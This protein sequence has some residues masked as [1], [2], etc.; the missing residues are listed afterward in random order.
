MLKGAFFYLTHHPTLVGE[1]ALDFSYFPSPHRLRLAA[2]QF[3]I[4]SHAPAFVLD[5]EIMAQRLKVAKRSLKK[6]WKSPVIAYSFKTNYAPIARLRRHGVYADVTSDRELAY[7]LKEGY[8][9]KHII[10][11]G[12]NKTRETIRTAWKH[13]ALIQIDN[14]EEL[15]MIH[16]MS[17]SMRLPVRIGCRLNPTGHSME[18]SRFGLS[19]NELFD[20]EILPM[21]IRS[22]NISFEGV[23]FHTG[24]DIDDLSTFEKAATMAGQVVQKFA[25]MGVVLRYVNCGGGVKAHGMKPYDK[26][27]WHPYEFDAYVETIWRALK[28]QYTNAQ[29]LTIMIE[30]GRY[31]VDDASVFIVRVRRVTAGIKQ[32]VYTDGSTAMLPLSQYRPQIVRAYSPTFS[33]RQSAPKPTIVYGA[34][35]REEDILY[36]GWLPELS[37]DDF[38]VF[39]SVGAYNQALASDFIYEK[40]NSYVLG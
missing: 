31:L 33:L 25:N 20:P 24:S 18:F 3:S 11:N 6:Y 28:K 34:T 23:H 15:M 27:T 19:P 32:S 13:N 29:H 5:M 38:L 10:F 16:A 39:Y 2:R 9:G 22:K 8:P 12:P 36:R 4:A 35:L 1:G 26:K 30:P 14:R 7:A 17:R 21:L 40:P 37:P